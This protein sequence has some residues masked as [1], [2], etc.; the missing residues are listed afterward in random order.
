MS[1]IHIWEEFSD[2]IYAFILSKVKDRDLANDILQDVFLKIHTKLDTLNNDEAL[3]GWL[4][5]ITR[6]TITD[7]YRKSQKAR[8]ENQELKDNL[9]L[10]EDEELSQCCEACL[11]LFIADLPQ[12][13]RD[14]ILAT[15]LGELSQ[16]EYAVKIGLSHSGVKSRVQRGRVQLNEYFKKCCLHKNEYGESECIHKDSYACTCK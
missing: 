6:N 14:A 11:H 4:F 2:R 9:P 10:F 12:K 8:K 16:K 15:D 5:S 7:Y 13:Y 1:T 3:S